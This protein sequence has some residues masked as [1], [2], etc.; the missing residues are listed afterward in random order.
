MDGSQSILDC[1]LPTKGPWAFSH[2]KQIVHKS[3]PDSPQCPQVV[4][5]QDFCRACY[6]V[7]GFR[8][9]NEMFQRPKNNKVMKTLKAL[10]VCGGE[11][12]SALE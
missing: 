5:H 6:Q 10:S 3:N 2:R 11:A 12:K 1:T 4:K 9:Q 8:D 7:L